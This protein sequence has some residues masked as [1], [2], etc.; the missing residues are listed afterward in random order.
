MAAVFEDRYAEF[1]HG[2]TSF[3]G[4]W[5]MQTVVYM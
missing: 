2:A 5:N 1:T 3:G 4:V